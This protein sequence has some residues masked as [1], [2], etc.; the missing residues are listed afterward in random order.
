MMSSQDKFT[1]PKDMVENKPVFSRE[2]LVE[3]E[4][5]VRCIILPRVSPGQRWHEVQRKKFPQR[6]SK[7][8]KDAEAKSS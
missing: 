4:R 3:M 1:S 5:S 2:R 7:T 6:F 8:H